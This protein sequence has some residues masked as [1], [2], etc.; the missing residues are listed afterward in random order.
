MV[1]TT[2]PLRSVRGKQP[3]LN[4][5]GKTLYSLMKAHGVGTS[6]QMAERLE[7]AGH[8]YSRQSV[9]D[10]ASGKT[11]PR[12][13]FLEAVCQALDLGAGERRKL[14]DAYAYGQD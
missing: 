4:T 12:G 14:A 6:Q 9:S 13:A 2:K 11:L 8:V 3:K 5:F 7:R 1:G 10:Y